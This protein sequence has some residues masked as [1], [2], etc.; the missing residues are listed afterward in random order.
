VDCLACHPSCETC[1][2]P[3][4]TECLTCLT[5]YFEDTVSGYCCHEDCLT[6]SGST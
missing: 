6:C 5:P 2:G 3:L 4:D 1:T